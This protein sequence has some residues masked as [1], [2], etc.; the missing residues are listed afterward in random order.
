MQNPIF[1]PPADNR[2]VAD[3]R[4]A[5]CLLKWQNIGFAGLVGRDNVVAGAD[6]GFSSQAC[7]HTEVHPTVI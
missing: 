5:A 3:K 2:H 4:T 6:C 7:Y 1:Q